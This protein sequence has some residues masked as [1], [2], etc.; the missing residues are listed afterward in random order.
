MQ[1][2]SLFG[3][4][5][6]QHWSMWRIQKKKMCKQYVRQRIL[7]VTFTPAISAYMEKTSI[8]VNKRTSGVLSA[9]LDE[10]D[11]AEEIMMVTTATNAKEVAA[12]IPRHLHGA[13]H[14]NK[15]EV[16]NDMLDAKV[17]YCAEFQKSLIQSTGYELVESV[18]TDRFWS[19]GRTPRD[20]HHKISIL[21]GRKK[22]Q[23]ACSNLFEMLCYQILPALLIMSTNLFKRR[24]RMTINHLHLWWNRRLSLCPIPL[25]GRLQRPTRGLTPRLPRIQLSVRMRQSSLLL[26]LLRRIIVTCQL[27]H[28]T[29]RHGKF[30]N[31][32]VLQFFSKIA[33]YF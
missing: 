7:C 17:K 11:L 28:G 4:Q 32:L 3:P 24:R 16:M 2:L 18:R 22:I 6:Q 30:L 29:C 31:Q 1:T 5:Q 26:Q 14:D 27:L 20:C 19:C 25:F 21:S 8:V 33:S 12:R 13:W 15:L 23:G 10:M 9:I